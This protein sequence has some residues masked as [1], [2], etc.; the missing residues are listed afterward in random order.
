EDLAALAGGAFPRAARAV[1]R[2]IESARDATV[3][4]ASAFT[5]RGGAVAARSG[6]VARATLHR[7]T[8]AAAF[9]RVPAVTR[10]AA[11]ARDAIPIDAEERA[12]PSGR[13]ARGE[14]SREVDRSHV[15]RRMTH[16]T[17]S[18][19]RERSLFEGNLR[20]DRCSVHASRAC[21]GW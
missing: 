20:A 2:G 17:S 3:D 10:C 8:D 12:A 7:L 15:R 11:V 4:T 5:A 18:A 1:G 6:A 9:A 19:R 14:N 16:N 13:G 21:P